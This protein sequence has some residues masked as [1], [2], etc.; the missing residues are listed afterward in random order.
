MIAGAFFAANRGVSVWNDNPGPRRVAVHDDEVV[1]VNRSVHDF[2]APLT[3]EPLAPNRRKPVRPAT[4]QSAAKDEC[5]ASLRWAKTLDKGRSAVA[6]A[7]EG[8]GRLPL[9]T[10]G[11]GV[12]FFHGTDSGHASS[13]I[14]SSRTAGVRRAH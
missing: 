2:P 10:A 12:W 13:G 4:V 14:C 9:K 5:I 8:H 3:K 6:R 1:P 7:R 11:P